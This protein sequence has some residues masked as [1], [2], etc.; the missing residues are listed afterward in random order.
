MGQ[1][2]SQAAVAGAKDRNTHQAENDANC[3]NS[4]YA[5]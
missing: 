4:F 2:L 1:I 5:N 3:V